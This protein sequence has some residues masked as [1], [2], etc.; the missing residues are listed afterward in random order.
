MHVR[1][2]T[3]DQTTGKWVVSIAASRSPLSIVKE[4][5]EYNSRDEAYRMYRYI[6]KSI[7][8]WK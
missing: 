4:R 2:P 8:V 6:L 7:G 5:F 3:H 1:K